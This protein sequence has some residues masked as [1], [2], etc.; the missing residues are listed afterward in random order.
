VDCGDVFG[1]AGEQD[2]LKAAFLVQTMEMLGYDIVNIGERE[3]NFGQ[4]FLLDEFK[5]TKMDLVS[6]NLV[7]ASSKKPLAKPFVVRK[8]GT[9]RVA[10]AGLIGKDMKLRQFPGDPAL[11]ILDP[12]STMKRLLPE[13]R[14]KADVV[15]LLSHLGMTE[16]QK[17]TVEVPGIDLM[18]FGHQ[19]GLYRTLAKTQEV[20]TVRGG[21]RGQHIPQVHLVVEDKKI[22]SF[23][24]DVVVL[25]DKMPADAAMA[26]HVTEF[27][28]QLNA[29]MN[30][31]GEATAQ[32]AVEAT[33]AQITGDRYLG[34]QN[35]R[36]CHEAEFEKVSKH[37]HAHALETLTKNQRDAT[38]ECLP[39][40]VVG[41]GSSGGFVSKQGTPHM[42]NVQCESCHG[43]GTQHPTDGAIV[44]PDVCM[45]CHTHEQNPDFQYD[46]MVAK[47]VHW[48]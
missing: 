46:E 4:R 11:E 44:G 32:K 13:M 40:H 48:D 9:V 14:K 24:G 15:V 17:L 22:T 6:A 37:P 18:V 3:L 12:A 26:K 10:F 28:N 36:R 1:L 33:Q 30:R 21:E 19:P 35:C 43:M 34:E 2:S 38:P 29:R 41:M 23:D 16:S 45:R 8:A 27:E 5:K 47:I 7:L 39:C 20:I 25:D 42:A 31:A